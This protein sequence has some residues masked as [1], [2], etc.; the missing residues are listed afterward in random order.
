MVSGWS[1]QANIHT[2][3]A[4]KSR[5]HVSVGLEL[6]V[7]SHP[8]P[9][10]FLWPVSLAPYH[11]FSISCTVTLIWNYSAH[12][13]PPNA[14]AYQRYTSLRPYWAFDYIGVDW[15]HCVSSRALDY[16]RLHSY[17]VIV[18]VNSQVISHFKGIWV[19]GLPQ[20][21]GNWHFN[22]TNLYLVPL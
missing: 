11:V 1:K 6:H 16:L 5:S 10:D 20:Y 13:K 15:R 12:C 4:M 14:H 17:T 19:Q 8:L 18:C 22:K 2:N 7:V 3:V 21:R 9:A